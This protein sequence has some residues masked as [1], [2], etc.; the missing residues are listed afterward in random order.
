MTSS[1]KYSVVIPVYNN[2]QLTHQL[3]LDLFRVLPQDVEIVVADDCSTQW[4]VSAGLDWWA[5]GMFRD[6]LNIVRQEMNVRFL[7]NANSG[8]SNANGDVIILC[9]NDIRVYENPIPKIEETLEEYPVPTLMGKSLQRGDTGWNRFG[10]KI[11]PYLE[12]WFLAFLK[13]DW[14]KFG[15]FDE[16]FV[17]FDFEDVDLSTTFIHNGGT[18]VEL[19]VNVQHIGGQSIGYSVERQ[20][21]TKINQEKFENKWIKYD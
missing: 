18:I 6:R 20:R 19:D 12:G 2:W 14:N 10:D 9:N 15:G 4:E 17:P 3:L 16:R 7:R 11:F 8:V 5:N 1:N 21:Q 13:S